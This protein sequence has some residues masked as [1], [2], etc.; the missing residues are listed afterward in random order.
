MLFKEFAQ[1]LASVIISGESTD[2]FTRT[3]FDA[4]VSEDGKEIVKKYTNSSYKSFYNGNASISGIS[5]QISILTNENLKISLMLIRKKSNKIFVLPL[6]L[7][8]LILQ[9][10]TLRMN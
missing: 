4:I 2:T 3:L 5:K 9:L 7:K 8:Y 10:K 1:N 6:A